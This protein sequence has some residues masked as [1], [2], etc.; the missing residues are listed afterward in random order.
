MKIQN[1]YSKPLIKTND[2]GKDMVKFVMEGKSSGQ[3][4][5]DAFI[6]IEKDNEHEEQYFVIEY[7]FCDTVK[8]EISHPKYYFYKNKKKFIELWAITRKLNGRLYAINYEQN[9]K[10][11]KVMEIVYVDD[12]KILTKNDTVMGIEKFKVWY[13]ALNAHNPIELEDFNNG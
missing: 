5:L 12:D 10:T 9:Y 11:F 2:L 8:P 4:D 3:M 6:H 1:Y 7:L 13:Q